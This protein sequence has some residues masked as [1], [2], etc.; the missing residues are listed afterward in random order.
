MSAQP[1]TTTPTPTVAPRH[2]KRQGYSRSINVTPAG[3]AALAE[4]EGPSRTAQELREIAGR[5]RDLYANPSLGNLTN[6]SI[7][8]DAATLDRLAAEVGGKR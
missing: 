7:A 3:L 6:Q 2:R 8:A 5:L 1:Q 4:A